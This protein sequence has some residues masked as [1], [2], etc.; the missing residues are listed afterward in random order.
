MGLNPLVPLAPLTVEKEEILGIRSS[1]RG[2]KIP[3]KNERTQNRSM[4][5]KVGVLNKTTSSRTDNA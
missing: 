2:A 3:G 1:H 5:S 4:L